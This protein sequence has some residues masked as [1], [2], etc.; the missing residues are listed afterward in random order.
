MIQDNG[1]T[2]L[3]PP[4]VRGELKRGH[5]ASCIMHRGNN[6]VTLIELVITMVLISI[7][8]YIV[9][10]AMSTG[11][12]A[13][14]TTDYRKE[15]L[16]QGRIALDRMAKEIRNLKSSSST[17][18]GTASATEFCFKTIEDKIMSYRYDSG[19]KT[20]IRTDLSGTDVS[21]VCPAS[22]GNTIANNITSFEFKNADATGTPL[23]ITGIAT[24]RRIVIALTSTKSDQGVSLQ[25]EVWPR[26]L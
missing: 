22:G 2:P 1:H 14:F 11:T 3:C 12:K 19:S 20:I 21:A 8:A 5:R 10:N 18:I 15:A 13:F 9:A 6:G 4:L 17:D 25:T 16:D 23:D 7:V 26:N 24:N